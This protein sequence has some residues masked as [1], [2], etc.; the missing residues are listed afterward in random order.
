MVEQTSIHKG[1]KKF[2]EQYK[3]PLEVCRTLEML[4]VDKRLLYFTEKLIPNV[5]R[6]LK[7]AGLMA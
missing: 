5:D 6:I 2:G 3:V 4:N 7:R 1:L